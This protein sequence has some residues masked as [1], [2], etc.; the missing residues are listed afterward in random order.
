MRYHKD[1][2]KILFLTLILIINITFLSVASIAY[3]QSPDLPKYEGVEQSI[4]DFLCAPSEGS[5]ANALTTCIN[6]LYRFGITV[7]GIMLVFFIVLAGY[8]YLAG[9]E[10]SKA[11]GKSI[12]QNAL[13]GVIILLFSYTLLN[14]LN[15]NL[16]MFRP[17]QPP[18]FSANMPTCADLGLGENCLIS[19][20]GSTEGSYSGAGNGDI[21]AAARNEVDNPP[22]P[23]L[24]QGDNRGENI[25]KY[26][27]GCSVGPGESWCACFAQWVYRQAGYGALMD[28][29]RSAGN[30]GTRNWMEW[31]QK[32]NGQTI[33]GAKV[34]FISRDDV[35]SGKASFMPG[36]VAFIDRELP[37]PQ[38]R[39]G[40]T[41]IIE[42]YDSATKK[43]SSIDGNSSNR[44]KR[45]TYQADGMHKGVPL[46]WGAMRVVK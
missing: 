27:K 30:A 46:F 33:A 1:K 17:I 5:N 34:L 24:E 22:Q 4:Q 18:I 29:V 14:F 13:L 11:K 32:N 41:F 39:F 37:H 44:V 31:A 36:D 38:D 20:A 6:R 42:A 16:A 2:N 9:G 21:V 26:F 12:F 23:K 45:N 19:L 7:G 3:G 8:F 10:S 40:H 15:P 25:D 43:V 28:V 35:V